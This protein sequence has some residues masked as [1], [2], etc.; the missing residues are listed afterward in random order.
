MDETM[1]VMKQMIA[2]QEKATEMMAEFILANKASEQR[3]ERMI[4]KLAEISNS[5]VAI[6]HFTTNVEDDVKTSRGQL[7]QFWKKK[8]NAILWIAGIIGTVGGAGSAIDVFKA[9]MGGL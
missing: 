1:L 2:A 8:K 4:E 6:Q 3:D 5:L 7:E 9:I